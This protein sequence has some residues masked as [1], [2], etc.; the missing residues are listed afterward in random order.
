VYAQNFLSKS[1][2]MYIVKWQKSVF[3]PI[4]TLGT[5][6]QKVTKN[7]YKFSEYS[8]MVD[9][10][11]HFQQGHLILKYLLYYFS[12]F[13][14]ENVSVFEFLCRIGFF[15]FFSFPKSIQIAKFKSLNKLWFQLN[16]FVSH[17]FT[18]HIKILNW[19]RN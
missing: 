9:I 1:R 6:G 16:I 15:Q 7:V 8:T 19:N 18:K 3:L 5:P 11:P 2:L 13:D 14:L 4:S 10:R 12:L 17:R